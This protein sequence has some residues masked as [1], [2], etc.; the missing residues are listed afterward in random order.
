M[1]LANRLASTFFYYLLHKSIFVTQFILD[2][3]YFTVDC[4]SYCVPIELVLL[5][6]DELN[7]PRQEMACELY[8]T[9]KDGNVAHLI[10]CEEMVVYFHYYKCHV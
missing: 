8:C 6:T 4:S 7:N 1:S 2:N 5:T 9:S 10:I 3:I